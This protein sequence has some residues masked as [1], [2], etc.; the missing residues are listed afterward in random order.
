MFTV[1]NVQTA[2]GSILRQSLVRKPE[3]RRNYCD[4]DQFSIAG[5]QTL[6]ETHS[7][8]PDQYVRYSVAVPVA[9]LVV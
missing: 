9:V 8:T 3:R 2:A 1:N 5:G 7:W 4:E 6:K